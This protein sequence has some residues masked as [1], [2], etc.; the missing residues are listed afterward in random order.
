MSKKKRLIGL[1]CIAVLCSRSLCAQ[2]RQMS[3]EELFS[4]ADEQSN[5]VSASVMAGMFHRRYV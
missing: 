2:T 3:L 4:L 5:H 1:L